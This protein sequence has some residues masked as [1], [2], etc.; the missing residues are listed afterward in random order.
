MQ[1]RTAITSEHLCL[2][3]EGASLVRIAMKH[4]V[5]D[6]IYAENCENCYGNPDGHL[7]QDLAARDAVQDIMNGNLNQEQLQKHVDHLKIYL[8]NCL[9][10]E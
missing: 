7:D 3:D 10:K 9:E 8:K 5:D 1:G 6:M 2:I 4:R